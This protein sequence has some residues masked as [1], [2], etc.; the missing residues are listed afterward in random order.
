LERIDEFEIRSIFE[1]GF[2]DDGSELVL[3]PLIE[4]VGRDIEP[5]TFS[6]EDESAADRE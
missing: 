6:R 5:P 1:Y 3:T 2:S 4:A